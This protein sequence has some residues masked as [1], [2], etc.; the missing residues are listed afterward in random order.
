[1]AIDAKEHSAKQDYASLFNLTYLLTF[2]DAAKLYEDTVLQIVR[3]NRW[4]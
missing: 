2:A 4:R 3:T 1:M